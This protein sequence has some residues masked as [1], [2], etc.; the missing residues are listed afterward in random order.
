[1]RTILVTVLLVAAASVSHAQSRNGYGSPPTY[2]T[3]SNSNSHGTGGY[4]TN[5]GTYVQP[6]QQTNPNG[7]QYDNYGAR[8]NTNP[9]Y[10]TTGKSSPK[11]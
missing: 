10:G 7:T 3:G 6:H 9:Y 11:Y 8:G 1:M 4:T 2:G 5:Q